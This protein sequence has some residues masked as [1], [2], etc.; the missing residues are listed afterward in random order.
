MNQHLPDVIRRQRLK[1]AATFLT[2]V[3][4]IVGLGGFE[5]VRAVKDWFG[6]VGSLLLL[7]PALH[8]EFSKLEISKLRESRAHDPDVRAAITRELS[9]WE[10][11]LARYR[12]WHSWCFCS[13]IGLLA[14]AFR[15]GL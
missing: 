14:L 7:V 15:S 12:A 6:F 9:G 3:L 2:I 13:G 1:A 4:I 8:L 5:V 11:D 10:S